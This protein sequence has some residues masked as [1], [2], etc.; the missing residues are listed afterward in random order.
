MRYVIS[1]HNLIPAVKSICIPVLAGDRYDPRMTSNKID[2]TLAL[3]SEGRFLVGRDRIKLLEAVA[4]HGSIAKAAKAIGYSYKTAWD[5]VNAINNLLPRPAFVTQAG[6]RGGGGG[7]TITD[8]GRRLIS[9]FHALEEK[10]SRIS[11]IIAESGLEGRDDLFL[12]GLG[13]KVSTRNVFSAEIEQVERG[14][15]D[16]GVSL[17]VSDQ[18]AL[19]S[20]VTNEAAEELGLRPGARALALIKSSFVDL[21][22]PAAGAAPDRNSF[23]G[24]VSRRIDGPENSEILVVIDS[25]K[26]M[27]AVIPRARADALRIAVG[28]RLAASFRASDVILAVG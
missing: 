12:F 25:G 17:R 8:E 5:S 24:E 28:E 26:T 7:A 3:R 21:D 4:E 2:A 1:L 13:V 23:I 19:R 9:T 10:L 18:V 22:P 15:V 6:G 16:V 27:T 20:I 14:P 11:S